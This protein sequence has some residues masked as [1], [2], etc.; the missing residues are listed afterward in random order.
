MI[1]CLTLADLKIERQWEGFPPG[2]DRV[3]FAPAFESY[4]RSDHQGGLHLCRFGDGRELASLEETGTGVKSLL[5]SP[6]SRWLAFVRE[7]LQLQLWDLEREWHIRPTLPAVHGWAVAF[8]S[9]SRLVAVGHDDGTISLYDLVEKKASRT[10]KFAAGPAMDGLFFDPAGRW[11]A[12]RVR[13]PSEV[14]LGDL[15]TDRVLA[16]CTV[17]SP[18][19]PIASH[20][21]KR[22]VFGCEDGKIRLWE[23]AGGRQTKLLPGHTSV[24]HEIAIDPTGTLLASASWDGTLR[25]WDAVSGTEMFR[26]DAD[27]RDL[28]FSR[29]GLELAGNTQ[30]INVGLWQVAAGSEHQ[31]MDCNDGAKRKRLGDCAVSP[32]GRL[33]AVASEDG[34]RLWDIGSGIELGKAPSGA[35][36]SVV[37]SRS[38]EHLITAGNSGLWQ[39]HIS[40]AAD[41]TAELVFAPG[42][43][44]QDGPLQHVG[45]SAGGEFLAVA[46]AD[47]GVSVLPMAELSAARPALEQERAIGATVSGDGRWVAAATWHGRGVRVWDIQSGARY[48]LLEDVRLTTV[49]FSA[50]DRWLVTG[51]PHEFCFWQTGSW[52]LRR[53]VAREGGSIPGAI[54]FAPC[55]TI[56]ALQTAPSQVRLYHPNSLEELCTLDVPNGETVGPMTFVPDGSGLIAVGNLEGH[57]H[58]WDL[59]LLRRQLARSGLDWEDPAPGGR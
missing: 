3:R 1:G 4:V 27:V 14:R 48:D 34:T 9:A 17:D 57:V 19:G 50:D 23:I 25:L 18:V 21:G 32:D 10:L 8:D 26:T 31:M 47:R 29:D 55:R 6:D 36:I 24:V 41:R 28:R 56:F 54:A 44:L 49:C 2:S 42:E 20:D 11:L 35:T 45:L 5:F 52:Q 16:A 15:E 12:A 30:G 37:F 7:G 40:Q 46:L 53:R 58:L 39:W 51:A 59:A 13:S 33:L 22:L 43:K 38:G